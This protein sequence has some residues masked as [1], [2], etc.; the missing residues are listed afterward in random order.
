MIVDDFLD[1][2]RRLALAAPRKPKQA[3]LRRAISTAYYA[4]FHAFARDAANLLVGGAGKELE[5]AWAQTYRALDHGAAKKACAQ[6][7]VPEF[8]LP[9]CAAAEV[10]VTLQQ[11]RHDADYDPSMI[12]KR[13]VLY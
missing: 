4:L 1:I 13:A 9:I 10:F 7:R 12:F 3:D 6:V 8:P 2:A 11:H 5:A